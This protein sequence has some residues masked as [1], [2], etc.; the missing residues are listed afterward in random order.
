MSPSGQSI[1]IVDDDVIL[2]RSL[3]RTL[4]QH[5]FDVHAV[6]NAADALEYVRSNPVGI[7]LLDW[8]LPDRDGVAMLQHLRDRGFH[9]PVIM[10]TG[11]NSVQGKVR[12]LNRGADD[13]LAKPVA[14]EELIA[15]VNALVRRASRSSVS[16][17]G[18]ISLNTLTH[19]AVVDGTRIDLTP[20]EYAILA[21]L[22]R[23]PNE[24]VTRKQLSEAVWGEKGAEA[25]SKA[26]DVQLTRLRR[27]LGPAADQI[28]TIRGTGI[29]LR[30][31]PRTS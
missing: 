22:A 14:V 19:E 10:L 27:K 28:E 15:R 1:L 12:A 31:E 16:R 30:T 18:R 25:S 29:C 9:V 11:Q 2:C 23:H 13:Y 17:L 3:A 26:I 8:I 24:V 20:L 4:R 7:I 5:G 21:Y 6:H